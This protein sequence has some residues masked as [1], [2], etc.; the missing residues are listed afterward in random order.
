MTVTIGYTTD[1]AFIAFA[2]ARGVTVTTPNAPIAKG[3][4]FAFFETDIFPLFSY[5]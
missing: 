1:D 2:L 5:L 3:R 4:V